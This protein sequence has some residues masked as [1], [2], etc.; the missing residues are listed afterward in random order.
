MLN[1]LPRSLGL[2]TKCTEKIAVY[3]EYTPKSGFPGY[4]KKVRLLKIIGDVC[5]KPLKSSVVRLAS[6]LSR[7]LVHLHL[8][9]WSSPD[10]PNLENFRLVISQLNYGPAIILETGTSAWGSDSTRLWDLYVSRFGGSLHSID[11]RPDAA[12]RLRYQVS[13][14]TKLWTQDSISF[15]LSYHGPAPDFVYLDSYDVNPHEPLLAAKHGLDEF[16][17]IYPKLKSGS[18]V[19]IDDTPCKVDTSTFQ[20]YPAMRAFVSQFG[21]N[22]GKGA[23]ILVHLREFPRMRLVSHQYSLLLECG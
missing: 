11:I 6:F 17:A 1:L 15:L 20:R 7:D 14:R 21:Q 16:R 2:I 10:H 8:R 22:P 4:I 3:A 23:L 18:L 13:S 9:A 19:L 12:R 5:Y